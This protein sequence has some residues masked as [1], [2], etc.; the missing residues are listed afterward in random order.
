MMKQAGRFRYFDE[1]SFQAL[2]LP[3]KGNTL[4]MVILLPKAKD[5]LDGLESS[6]DPRED[7]ELADEV[8]VAPCRS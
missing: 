8:V 7:R 5:G 3:Y 4:A 6:L 2:E 1:G